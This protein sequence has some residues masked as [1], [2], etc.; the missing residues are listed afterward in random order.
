MRTRTLGLRAGAGV[1]AALLLCACSGAKPKAGMRAVIVV[2]APVA[3]AGAVA[4][5]IVNG[6]RL[7]VDEID[8]S[9]GVTVGGRSVALSLRTLDS[10]LS[11]ATSAANT[12]TAA[13]LG[14]VAIVDEGTGVDASWRIANAAGIPIGIVYQGAMSLVDPR[15][16]PNVFR[17]A[18]TDRGV[19]FRL[20][21]YLI[22]KGVK[23][24]IL[25]DDSTYG[26]GG[27][28]ALT[29]AFE[30]NATS[31]SV[32]LTIPS[33]S[34]DVS[35][36]VLAA[37]RSSATAL[38]VWT[39]PALLAAIVRQARSTGWDVPVF[40]GVTGGDPIVRQQLADHPTWVDGLTFTLSRLTSEKGAAPYD[41]F[42][43][44]YEKRFG[45]EMVG[46]RS[47]GREVVQVP[48][49]AMYS[50]DFVKVVAGAMSR[51]GTATPG[52][53]LLAQLNDIDVVGANGDERSFNSLN[54]EGVVD[55]DVFF[56]AFHDMVWTP[57]RDDPLSATLPAIPQT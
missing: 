38:L 44:A 36:Q 32:S 8:R 15:T 21:E 43:S 16:R 5:Q 37:R 17:I 35:A 14:A 25:R 49:W 6:A 9:G 26:D 50:Y 41:A 54:H 20:A 47:R 33:S 39:R 42:R 7:A 23:I 53:R 29:Q 46:V 11:P 13:S 56:A 2:D 55:D 31:L 4:Q 12:R 40:S 24:A 22:P 34:T 27:A 57:V 18:P 51:A 3:E 19:A 10:G 30:R 48:D 45:V 28:A 52:P 1:Y